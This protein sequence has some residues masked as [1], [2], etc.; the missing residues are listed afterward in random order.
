MKIRYVAIFLALLTSS[1]AQ[2]NQI[3]RACLSSDRSGANRT[4][5]GCIQDAADLTLTA[6]DQKLASSFFKDPQKAQN[7]RQSDRRAH[8]VFWDRYK[9]FGDLAAEFCS[10]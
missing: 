3:E 6:P 8:E 4:V 2:A 9:V 1:A 5:C 10:L 7:I